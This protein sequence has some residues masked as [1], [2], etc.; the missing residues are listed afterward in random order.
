MHLSVILTW[1]EYIA[2]NHPY[3]LAQD[4]GDGHWI[5]LDSGTHVF[6]KEGEGLEQ[7]IG[8][9]KEHPI[10]HL[11]DPKVR[12]NLENMTKKT[13]D[14]KRER[15]VYLYKKGT[16]ITLGKQF[17]GTSRGIYIDPEDEKR[18]KEKEGYFMNFH[19]HPKGE[20]EE[21]LNP[22][23]SDIWGYSRDH[24]EYKSFEGFAIGV[25]KGDGSTEIRVWKVNDWKKFD[26]HSDK[27][28]EIFE[29]YMDPKNPEYT[30]EKYLKENDSLMRSLNKFLDMKKWKF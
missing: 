7:S 30:R 26:E 1:D 12:G 28:H 23:P 11:S 9:L 27:M 15:E 22:S 19:T 6:I 4:E 5:T 16:K 18:E 13:A 3:L 10:G 20:P 21:G 17:V 25:V 8:R 2:K 24:K 14:T 29:K